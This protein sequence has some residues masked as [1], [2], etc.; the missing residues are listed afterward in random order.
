MAHI[1]TTNYLLESV[2][3]DFQAIASDLEDVAGQVLDL[4][5]KLDVTNKYDRNMINFIKV[6]TRTNLEKPGK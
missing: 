4:S 5:E 3:D 2:I 6:S 1:S